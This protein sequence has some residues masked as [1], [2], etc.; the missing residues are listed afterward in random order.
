MNSFLSIEQSNNKIKLEEYNSNKYLSMKNIIIKNTYYK[1]RNNKPALYKKNFIKNNTS[2]INQN[3][4][5]RRLLHLSLMDFIKKNYKLKNNSIISVRNIKNINY[6][7]NSNIKFLFSETKKK[8]TKKLITNHFTQ[9]YNLFNK[10]HRNIEHEEGKNTVFGY[11]YK[12]SSYINDF[13][14]NIN[15][16]T[17]RKK[18]NLKNRVHSTVERNRFNNMKLLGKNK[19]EENNLVIDFESPMN[20]NIFPNNKIFYIKNKNTNTNIN[21]NDYNNNIPYLNKEPLLGKLQKNIENYEKN[22]NKQEEIINQKSDKIHLL[23][24][25]QSLPNIN[26]ERKEDK[27]KKIKSS[28]IPNDINRRINSQKNDNFFKDSTNFMYSKKKKTKKVFEYIYDKNFNAKFHFLSIKFGIGNQKKNK[29]QKYNNDID[30]IDNVKEK[31]EII[32]KAY[33]KELFLNKELSNRKNNKILKNYSNRNNYAYNKTSVSRK[34]TE[35]NKNNLS[36]KKNDNKDRLNEKYNNSN[37]NMNKKIE[38]KNF[39]KSKYNKFDIKKSIL[40][41]NPRNKKDNEKNDTKTNILN[42]Q[43]KNNK[44]KFYYTENGFSDFK[45]NKIIPQNPVAISRYVTKRKKNNNDDIIGL[46]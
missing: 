25:N 35:E 20:K 17:E 40:F 36:N 9:D 29:Y 22:K 14:N 24:K 2:F 10:T 6:F 13:Y 3:N 42:K 41:F 45:K 44:E 4:D 38:M 33:E 28:Y 30:N 5:F 34:S 23:K 12:N 16:K 37:N 32:V 31:E 15:N 7:N 8:L 46:I 26:T 1:E 39:Y 21:I 11:K 19:V 27:H 18:I 43:D